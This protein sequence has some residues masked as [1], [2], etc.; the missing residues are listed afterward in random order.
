MGGQ[1][2]TPPGHGRFQF[3]TVGASPMTL[4]LEGVRTIVKNRGEFH[5]VVLSVEDAGRVA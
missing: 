3:V 5:V 1:P 4:D 2:I